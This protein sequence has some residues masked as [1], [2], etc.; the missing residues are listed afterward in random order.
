MKEQLDRRTRAAASAWALKNEIVLLG[1]GS[2]IPIPGRGD[3]TYP[4]RAHSEYLYLTDRERPGG[5]LAYDPQEGWSDF[6]PRVTDDEAVWVGAVKDEG[7]PLSAFGPW[8]EKRKGRKIA[9]L[10][11]P[12][13][14]IQADARLTARLREALTQ[15]RRPKDEIELDRMRKAEQATRAGFQV[16]NALVKPGT[17]ERAVQIEMEAAF[18]RHGA[19]RVAYDT[20][21]GGGP[22]SAVFHFSPTERQFQNGEL[23]LVDAGAEFKAYASDVTRTYPASGR[24]STEQADIYNI[25]LAVEKAAIDRCKPG[26]EYK[27]VHLQAATEI[28][29]GLIDFGLLRGTAESLVEQGVH[30]LFFPHGIGHMVGLGVRDAGGYL[31]D[32]QPSDAPG[33]R[34]LRI[35]LPL[36]PGYVVTIEPGIYFIPVLLQNS[37]FR[38]RYRDAVHWERV[39]TMLGFGGIRIEDNVHITQDGREILTADIP[40]YQA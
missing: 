8:L 3:Q 15:I 16:L 11:S 14:N 25:V 40:K 22:N 12:V 26:M 1:S 33:L 2:L 32:R 34:Y 23:V 28:A 29:Q 20:I 27:Q 5:V 4:F 18:F 9:C 21:V 24:F 19:D 17:T 36:K 38:K 10:G 13:P 35:D 6:V 39:D 7:V 31:P 30:A 37:D